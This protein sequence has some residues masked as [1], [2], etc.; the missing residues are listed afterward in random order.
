MTPTALQ[1]RPWCD[2]HAAADPHAA[3]DTGF[4]SRTVDVG[5]VG[6]ELADE[7]DGTVILLWPGTDHRVTPAQAR[8]V[9]AELIRAA[10]TVEQS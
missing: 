5:G 3:T 7:P 2:D 6:V 8:Q 10:E 1:H 4:C 9:A